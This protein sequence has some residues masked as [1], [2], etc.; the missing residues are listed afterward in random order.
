MAGL[1]EVWTDA[2]P[3]GRLV[4]GGVVLVALTGLLG[5]VGVDYAERPKRRRKRRR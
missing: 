2:T 1:R 5:A 3:S 4:L